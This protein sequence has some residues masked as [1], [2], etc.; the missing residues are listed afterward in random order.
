MG[1]PFLQ[2]GKGMAEWGLAGLGVPWLQGIRD[3]GHKNAL[4]TAGPGKRIERKRR[5]AVLNDYDQFE[6]LHWEMGTLR[7]YLAYRGVRNPR[8]TIRPM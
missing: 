1:M 3:A 7:N 4:A 2:F 6:G 5:M 8:A